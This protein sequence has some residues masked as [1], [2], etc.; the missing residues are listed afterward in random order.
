V[1]ADRWLAD[2]AP[3]PAALFVPGATADEFRSVPH[4][5]EDAESGAASVVVG[6]LGEGWDFHV[7]N[8]AFRLLMDEPRPALVEV[9]H[10]GIA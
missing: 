2:N 8:R 3:G 1:A 5:R 6:D 9:V 10:V 4:L 7:L